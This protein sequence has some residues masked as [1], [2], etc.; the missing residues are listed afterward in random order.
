MQPLTGIA[1]PAAWNSAHR[2]EGTLV[3]KRNPL[4]LGAICDA[5]FEPP[6]I[7]KGAAAAAFAEAAAKRSTRATRQKL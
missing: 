7:S 5:S 2:K 1:K 6:L 4:G 3:G